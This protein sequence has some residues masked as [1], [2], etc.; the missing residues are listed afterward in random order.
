MTCEFRLLSEELVP[1][2]YTCFREAFADY[3]LDMSYMTQRNWHNRMIKNGVNFKVSVGAF[4]KNKMV[5]FTAIGIDWWEKKKAA[6]DA[7]TGVIP[8]YRGKGIAG[9][10]LDFAVPALKKLDVTKFLLEVL[11]E[12]EAAVK[13]YKRVGFEITRELDCFQLERGNFKAP[14]KLAGGI[15]IQAVGKEYLDHFEGQADWQGS[16]ET[17]FSSVARIPDEVFLYGAFADSACV[18]LLSYYP[19][20]KWITTLVVEKDYRRRGI[21]GQLV[22][23]CFA[24]LPDDTEKVKVVNVLHTDKG[25]IQFL[26]GLGFEM[27]V[28]QFEMALPLES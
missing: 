11:Q 3:Q 19:G 14:G 5:G 1:Q 17:S 24:Q 20:L 15:T 25:I 16:W 18:G 6:F 26:E 21:A 22:T 4:D 27:Y 12:N 28:A 9:K 13:A 7:G 2:I 23:Y 8:P 10:M